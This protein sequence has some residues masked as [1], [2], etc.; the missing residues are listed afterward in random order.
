MS[1]SS[2]VRVKKIRDALE[3]NQGVLGKRERVLIGWI[4]G[5]AGSGDLAQAYPRLHETLGAR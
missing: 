5:R 1:V 4:F 2:I 3:E